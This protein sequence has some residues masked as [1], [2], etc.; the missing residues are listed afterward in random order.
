MLLHILFE[1]LKKY[2]DITDIRAIHINPHET[3]TTVKLTT[4]LNNK[5]VRIYYWEWTHTSVTGVPR[6]P[7]WECVEVC[8]ETEEDDV[9][10]NLWGAEDVRSE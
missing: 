5:M 7:H 9:A 4:R 10:E 1:M 3:G 8:T 2:T 6:I